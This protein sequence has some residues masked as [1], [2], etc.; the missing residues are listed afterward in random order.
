MHMYIEFY[1]QLF[2]ETILLLSADQRVV[3][4][5]TY[6]RDQLIVSMATVIQSER[7]RGAAGDN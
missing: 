7:D 1:E 6:F 4:E 5:I 2:L 3:E